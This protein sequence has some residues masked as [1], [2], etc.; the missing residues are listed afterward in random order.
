MTAVLEADPVRSQDGGAVAGAVRTVRV[1]LLGLGQV[2]QAVARLVPVATRLRAAGVQLRITGALV[3]EFDK[4]RRCPRPAR[5][6]SNPSAFLRGH[7]DVVVEAL[8]GTEPARTLV[9]RLLGRGVAVVTANKALVAAHGRDLTALAA[10][11]GTAFRFEA[12]A[13]AAVPFLGALAA[14]PLVSDVRS[15]TAIVNGTCNFILSKLDGGRIAFDAAVAEARA[16]GLTEPDASRDLDGLD[17]ADKLSL[18]AALFGWGGV[19]SAS[20]ETQSIRDIT[21][22]DLAVA[23]V[24][25]GTIKPIAYAA[26]E[27]AG[28]AAFVGPAFVPAH[29]PLATLAGTLSGIQLSGRFVSDLF[30]SGP[31]AG[32]DVTAATILDDVV[33]AVA[34]TSRPRRRLEDVA[35]AGVPSV[36][37]VTGWLVR[38]RFPGVVP[39][40]EAVAQILRAHH[41]EVVRVTEPAAHARD[42]NA[43]WVRIAPATRGHVDRALRS[44]A[45]THRISCHAFRSL[46]H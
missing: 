31:G 19:V 5:V 42:I 4:P 32:A 35:P 18:L 22:D 8:A 40:A 2:G 23:R 7:Y 44:A 14:R 11:R 46:E 30:F 33:E 36:P 1:G 3:R 16:L 38:A 29:H 10:R 24:L 6:T 13:L 37:A 34:G 21:A 39:D 27:P 45:T 12:S 28:I 26:R 41:L 25:G 20:E 15:F 17:A 9:S 43:R